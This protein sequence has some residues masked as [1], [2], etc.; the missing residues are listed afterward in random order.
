MKRQLI[1]I[2]M[3]AIG[4]AH[5]AELN[6]PIR[7]LA[8]A[9]NGPVNYVFGYGMVIGLEGTGDSRQALFSS[10]TLTTMLRRLGVELNGAQV[11]AKNVAGV[12]VTATLKP[13]GRA[14]DV[15]DVQVSAIGDA[16]T[17]QGGFLLQTMLQ[18]AS[19]QVR[20]VAQGPLSI[21]GFNVSS[22]G[23][24]VQKNHSCV[25]R[26][27]NGAVLTNNTEG[28]VA[29]G[30]IVSLKLYNPDYGT[31]NRLA[32]AIR[33]A[34][35][36]TQCQVMDPGRVTVRVP[37]EYRGREPLFLARIGELRV[38]PDVPAR[39]VVNERTG[40]VVVGGNVRLLPVAIAHGGLRIEISSTPIVSQPGPLTQSEG[41]KTV[42]VPDTTVS[43]KEEGRQLAL[44]DAGDSVQDLVRL[45]NALQVTPRD[46]IA[47]MQALKSSGALLAELEIM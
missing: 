17:L 42:V 16:S 34:F 40:T 9:D 18:D 14:G 37:A 23:S 21:G 32:D 28:A 44:V 8:S 6:V 3:L 41:A 25:G 36:W 33:E 10:Q 47:I 13:F 39:V 19:G 5:S 15:V 45:L 31:A 11:Q 30:G 27:P 4:A 26:I 46:L 7:D 24:T 38:R 1:L 43:A 22:G 35:G 20:A 2:V 29:P 12:M